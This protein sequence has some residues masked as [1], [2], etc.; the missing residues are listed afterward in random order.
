MT[1]LQTEVVTI[2]PEMAS[3]ILDANRD[4]RKIRQQIVERYARDIRHG[5]W[6]LN[7]EAVKIANDGTLIDG[8][9]RL[10]A[11]VEANT[12][13]D[14]VVVRGLTFEVRETM[15]TGAKRSLGDVLRWKGEANVA[16]LAAAIEAC[17][18]WDENGAPTNRGATHSNSERLAWLE[19]NPDV[20]DAV[21]IW[22]PLV[23]APLRITSAGGSPFYLRAARLAP[24]E[25]ESFVHLLKTGTNL[26]EDNPINRMRNWS[27]RA[28]AAKG[29]FAREEY[30]AV[31]VK[32][33]NAWV[34]GRPMKHLSW[35][36]GGVNPEEFP[37]M[38]GPDGRSYEDWVTA[39][40]SVD[41]QQSNIRAWLESI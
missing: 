15:D 8:Q 19:A 29:R 16:A 18:C 22:H 39:P 4:N 1:D 36:R 41:G 40:P 27:F 7:G 24:S 34:L 38:F 37:T 20:R 21:R 9:H 13:F 32:A 5:N 2:T 28:G 31:L 12:P 6:K 17:L 10:F 26:T 14:T 33:W 35:R 30:S 3:R 25:A 23:A 11:C